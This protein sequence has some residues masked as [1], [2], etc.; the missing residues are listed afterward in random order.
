MEEKDRYYFNFFKGRRIWQYQDND[1][2]YKYIKEL[3]FDK[4]SSKWQVTKYKSFVHRNN[5]N[6]FECYEQLDTFNTLF[7]VKGEKGERGFKSFLNRII[8]LNKINCSKIKIKKNKEIDFINDFLDFNNKYF[9]ISNK[10]ISKF[11]FKHF[12]TLH[13]SSTIEKYYYER[14]HSK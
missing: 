13:T 7:F 10:E 2:F 6:Y 1:K 9:K 5:L 8:K 11:I 3:F 14:K 12:E 4:A